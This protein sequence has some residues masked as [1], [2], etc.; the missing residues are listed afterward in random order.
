MSKTRMCRVLILAA[1]GLI[2]VL[3]AASPALADTSPGYFPP[4]PGWDTDGD[5]TEDIDDDCPKTPGPAA[6]KGCPWP[7]K[8]GD[9]ILDNEDACPN[10]PGPRKNEGCPIFKN[11]ILVKGEEGDGVISY[12]GWSI[13][14]PAGLCEER[15]YMNVNHLP[16]TA[17]KALKNLDGVAGTAYF[18]TNGEQQYK[19]CFSGEANALYRFVSGEWVPIP[20]I[21]Q[22]DSICAFVSGD[23]TFAAVNE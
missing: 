6:N 4:P 14:Y 19:V 18:A 12:G 3:A 9:G 7:D 10:A 11:R 13:H 20:F 15:C 23:G 8:D 1:L 16:H 22:G 17:E 2:L 21:Y 5:G